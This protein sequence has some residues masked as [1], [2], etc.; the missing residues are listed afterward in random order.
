M[1]ISATSW[2]VEGPHNPDDMYD[3]SEYLNGTVYVE[4]LDDGNIVIEVESA[5]SAAWISHSI[6]AVLG[7][8]VVEVA[9]TK[10]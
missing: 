8:I 7:G 10:I 4:E 1:S 2:W 3:L 9:N 5:A 6:R